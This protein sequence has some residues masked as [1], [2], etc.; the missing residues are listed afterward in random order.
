[1]EGVVLGPGVKVIHFTWNG[2][3]GRLCIPERHTD[4]LQALGADPEKFCLVKKNDDVYVVEEKLSE[5][6]RF[7]AF[8]AR[9]PPGFITKYFERLRIGFDWSKLSAFLR[10]GIVYDAVDG[11]FGYPEKNTVLKTPLSIECFLEN[12]PNLG[13]IAVKGDTSLPSSYV[14]GN[15]PYKSKIDYL[16]AFEKLLHGKDRLILKYADDDGMVDIYDSNIE[17][18]REIE[19]LLTLPVFPQTREELMARPKTKQPSAKKRAFE[20]PKEELMDLAQQTKQNTTEAISELKEHLRL[21]SGG[22][23]KDVRVDDAGADFRVEPEALAREMLK[24][25][26]RDDDSSDPT[27]GSE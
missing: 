19:L 4:V 11:W 3:E 6:D 10:P 13:I 1:M 21:M 5:S 24:R 27:E 2:K 17:R 14:F 9:L 26:K 15:G 16:F 22:V 20:M 23:G 18:T 25:S 7:D 8:K 12:T